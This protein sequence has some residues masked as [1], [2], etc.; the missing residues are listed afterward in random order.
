MKESEFIDQNKNKWLDYEKIIKQS[1]NDPDELSEVFIQVTDDLSHSRSHYPNRSVRV[2]LNDL[3]SKIFD[4]LGKRKKLDFEVIKNFYTI[5]V[6][7][8]MYLARKEMIVSFLIFILSMGIGIYS[9]IQNPEFASVVLGESYVEM[10]KA[11]IEKGEAMNVYTGGSGMG[12]FLMILE[13]NARIDVMM[14]GLGLFFSFGAIWV[15]VRNGIM[16]GVFQY[17]FVQHGGFQDSLLT[18]W[19]H[20]TIE[21]STIGL[22][23]GVALLAGK[24]L[25]F[26]GNYT[27]YQSWRLSAGNAGKLLL[28]VL[29]FTLLAAI[30]EGFVTRMTNMPDLIKGAFILMSLAVVVV[31]FFVYPA[32]VHKKHGANPLHE[33]LR[34]D[35]PPKAISEKEIKTTPQLITD[36]FVTY[37]SHFGRNFVL[38]AIAGILYPILMYWNFENYFQFHSTPAMIWLNQIFGETFGGGGNLESLIPHTASYNMFRFLYLGV[39]ALIL[40]FVNAVYVFKL[41]LSVTATPNYLGAA[42]S[43]LAATYLM[44]L[45]SV[46][47]PLNYVT[48]FGFLIFVALAVTFLLL[49]HYYK[50]NK[51]TILKIFFTKIFHFGLVWILVGILMFFVQLMV[52]SVLTSFVVY[53]LNDLLPFDALTKEKW[54][55]GAQIFI[56]FTVIIATIPFYMYVTYYMIL[57]LVEKYEA[58]HLKEE[59]NAFV[60]GE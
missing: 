23:G 53:V 26:P 27:R 45:S 49:A 24:G 55:I 48:S 41:K 59:V 20:G 54:A 32:M 38:C 51:S 2:Y 7:Q 35:H 4:K 60:I 15:L 47:F 10:T 19:L 25:L 36:A 12:G 31:Y 13:H 16:V 42:V 46:R 14:L 22:M 3:A 29:P 5:E 43:I 30:I 34:K 1:E 58:I 33:K 17:F 50:G 6:P 28:M 18:I 11:N 44:S 9:S 21:I 56:Y 39:W 40:L 37:K 52:H 57:S 8:L